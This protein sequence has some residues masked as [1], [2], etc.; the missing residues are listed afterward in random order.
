MTDHNEDPLDLLGDDGNGVNEMCLFFDKDDKN[1]QNG[2]KP[3]NNSGC[4]VILLAIGVSV[5][6]GGVFIIKMYSC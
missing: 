5:I 2:P 4:C 3:P 6:G 1:N